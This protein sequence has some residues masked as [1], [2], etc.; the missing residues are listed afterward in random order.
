MWAFRCA[1]AHQGQRASVYVRN[2]PT[3]TSARGTPKKLSK[4]IA[5]LKAKRI[6]LCLTC[7][8]KA[9]I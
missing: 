2:T 9:G 5:G 1:H 7:K 3:F 6:A 8:L 4:N